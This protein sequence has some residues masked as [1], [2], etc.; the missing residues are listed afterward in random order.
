VAVSTYKRLQ[1][2]G[3]QGIQSIDFM[4]LSML[5]SIDFLLVIRQ[6]LAEAPVNEGEHAIMDDVPLKIAV[7]GGGVAGIGA[8][9]LLQRRHQVSLFEKNDYV[10]GHTHTIVIDSGPDQG[11]P[12]DTG[13]IVL[14]D[15][16]YPLLMQFLAA[17]HVPIR[18]SDMSFSYTCR[19][20][21]LQYASRNLNTLFA[22]RRNLLR[23]SF[24]RFLIEIV[25]FNVKTRKG[26]A[27]GTLQG[28]S[29]GTYLRQEAVIPS[30]VETYL[31]PMAAAIWSTP[32]ARM[33]DFP[34]ESFFRFMENHG[35]LSVSDQPQWYTVEGGSHAYVKAFLKGF[36]GRVF[37]NRPVKH[38]RRTESGPVLTFADGEDDSYDAV[39]IA[40]HADE[41]L[42]LLSDPS[43]EETSCLAPWSYNRNVT[44][45][46]TDA[47]FIP[48]NPRARA[49][50]NYLREKDASREAPVMLTYHMNRLQGLRTAEDY[51]VTLNP[52]RAAERNRIIRELV[53]HHPMYTAEAVATQQ[54]LQGLNGQRH[55]YF[56]GSYFGYGF[57]EDALRSGVQVAEAFGIHL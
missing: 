56:C 16:T 54:S 7:V 37:S 30:L 53:Y 10:G 15:R 52:G 22:Q 5:I 1:S 55:T 51:C 11:T 36:T 4:E 8:A 29:L 48:D 2:A 41:A 38:I 42:G 50:W 21:G 19:R 57:H 32:D 13:F 3:I 28:L 14:N 24:W 9:Y 35:L 17:L 45:L 23:P 12:V 18:K 40:T 20:T 43:P 26:L 39:V 6:S 34:A 33:M 46:H 27:S 44:V 47:S 49:S 25:W 31:I